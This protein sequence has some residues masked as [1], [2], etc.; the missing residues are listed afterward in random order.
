[1]A[2]NE[3]SSQL[4]AL[5]KG[6]TPAKR[7][8][9]VAFVGI[10]IVGFVFLMNWAGSPDFQVLYSNLGPEDGGAIVSAL[11]E[12]RIHTKFPPMAAPFWRRVNRYM[13]SDSNWLQVVCPGGA[14]LGSR[15]L[16]M[17][18]SG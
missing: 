3:V 14:A 6:I 1:M 9:L 5:Y 11:K 18:S 17:P 2:T 4:K 16:T 8:T 10:T 12:K 15:F 13:T 7:L